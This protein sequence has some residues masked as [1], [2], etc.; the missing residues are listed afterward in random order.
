M[1]IKKH[2]FST[3]ILSFFLILKTFIP[4]A[5]VIVSQK[6]LDKFPINIDNYTGIDIPLEES[7]YK[8]LNPDIYI[9]RRYIPKSKDFPIILL[10]ISYYGT[11]KGGRTG[12]NPQ[13][14]YPSAGWAILNL[15]KVKFFISGKK[16]S[17]NEMLIQKD[18]EKR[19][20]LY[21]YQ[22]GNKVL[23]TGIKQNLHRF[24]SRIFKNR[25]DGAFVRIS[26]SMNGN[27]QSILSHVYLFTKRVLTLLPYYWPQ[28]KEI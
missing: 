28:E 2:Y 5:K 20:V 7:I 16:I 27:P 26:A 22:S 19:I 13:A 25:D 1:K 24:F 11:A 6:N 21:W 23:D 18:E 10:Y 3:I 14:C 4:S 17:I 15:K 12:H 8:E 9:F